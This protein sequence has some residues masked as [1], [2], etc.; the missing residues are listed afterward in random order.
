MVM[1][2]G[3]VIQFRVFVTWAL[4][5]RVCLASRHGQYTPEE[6]ITITNCTWTRG[7]AA[8]C[9]IALQSGK[10]RVRFSMGSLVF[11]ID[12]ILLAVL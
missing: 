11:C 3:M 5:A 4:H 10:S 1:Y 12:L 7:G 6:I 8:G 9:R 2:M